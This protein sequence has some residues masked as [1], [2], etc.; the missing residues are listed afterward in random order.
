MTRM[1]PVNGIGDSR[2]RG[3]WTFGPADLLAIEEHDEGRRATDSVFFR[4]GRVGGDIDAYNR[5]VARDQ[6]RHLLQYR[7]DRAAIAAAV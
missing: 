1:A 3:R 5:L 2:H 6:L 7:L 4:Q